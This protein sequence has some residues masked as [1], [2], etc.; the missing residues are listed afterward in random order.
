MPA[1]EPVVKP[2]GVKQVKVT[3]LEPNPHNPRML[4][5]E[6]PMKTLQES[7]AKVGILVPLTVYEKKK[8][9]D[10]YVI[11]DGQRRWMCAQKVR[12]V[13]VPVNIVPEPSVFQNIVTMFQIH[14]L[15]EDWDLMPTALKLQVLMD[16]MKE[17]NSRKLAELTA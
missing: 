8:D 9:P 11:L 2:I 6:A 3:D 14:K 13:E 17:S 7:I 1:H 16:E 4:F 10:R 15:R 5:D 12:L